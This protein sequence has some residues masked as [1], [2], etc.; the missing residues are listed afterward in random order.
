MKQGYQIRV[1]YQTYDG[2]MGF[3]DWDDH[4]SND[5]FE[6]DLVGEELNNAIIKFAKNKYSHFRKIESVTCLG[7]TEKQPVATIGEVDIMKPAIKLKFV[8]SRCGTEFNAPKYK[9]ESYQTG[10]NEFEYTFSCPECHDR[11]YSHEEVK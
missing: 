2:Y 10:M 1:Y 9:C 5:Y 6:T 8:C 3:D 7:P 11:C 4:Y